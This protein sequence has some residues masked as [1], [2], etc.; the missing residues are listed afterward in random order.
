MQAALGGD[1]PAKLKTGKL[2][3][4]FVF[5]RA[6][7]NQEARTVALAFSSETPVGRWFGEEILDHSPQSV[8]LTRL[9]DG[10]PL[11]VDHDFRDHI[12]TIESVEIGT[13]RVGRAVVRFGKSVRAEEI[14]QD[15]LDG[16]RKHVSITYEIHHMV[17]TEAGRDGKQPIYRADDWE[18]LEISIVSVPADTSVGVGRSHEAVTETVVED[19]TNNSP[20]SEEISQSQE[21]IESNISLEN[22]AMTPEEIAAKAAADKA[23]AEQT[24]RSAREGVMRNVNEVM[25]IGQQ[26]ASRGGEKIAAEFIRGGKTD[27]NEFR[28]VMMDQIGNSHSDARDA[29]IGLSDKEINQFSI[30]RALAAIMDNDWS[31]AGFEREVSMAAAKKQGR[32]ARGFFVPVEVLRRDMT[33]GTAAD[34]GNLVGTEL[35]P[36]DFIS[37]LR[38]AMMLRTL[39][40]RMITGL[41]GNIAIPRQTGGATAY[42]LA[43]N[44]APTETLGAID[45]VA[46]TPKTVG[47]FTDIARRLLLQSSL[48]VEQFVRADLAAALALEIDRVGI[49]GTGA[50]NMPTGILATSGIGDVAGGTNGLAPAWSHIVDLESKVSIANAD[51][52]SLAYLTNAKVRGKLKQTSQVSG[53][54]GF[55]WEKGGEPLNGYKAGVS[56]QVSSA[57]TKGSSSGVC[58]AILFGNWADLII[59]MWGGLDIMKD[60]YANSTSGGLRIVAMQDVDIAVRHAASFSAMKDALTT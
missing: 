47:A 24:E 38:N 21:Y 3:R 2:T 40:A 41:Q 53:Q 17:M 5:D 30:V 28:K 25:A 18:P 1:M 6:A 45:Q 7:A 42:W 60:P 31:G 52:G 16:I 56:N 9:A 15:V 33:V 26:F 19:A 10:G 48:D 46:M 22:T 54:N 44:G 37:M 4:E 20:E 36:Q 8:R 50:S 11:L 14:F 51:I 27:V 12:G 43:E 35:R 23:A 49:H 55:V 59:G 39:G 32:E 58:S 57:L 29:E 13:D 34:G